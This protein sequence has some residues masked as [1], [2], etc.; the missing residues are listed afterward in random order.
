MEDE[1]VDGEKTAIMGPTRTPPWCSL[2]L[3]RS[4]LFAGGSQPHNYAPAV[5]LPSSNEPP[6]TTY[7]AAPHAVTDSAY[8]AAR[9]DA[10][11]RGF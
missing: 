2:P 9:T 6:P 11:E 3:G 7:P 4:K 8:T 1:I 10:T 5:S